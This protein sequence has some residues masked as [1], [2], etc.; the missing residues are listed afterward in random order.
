MLSYK[1]IIK[2]VRGDA[3]T[4][5]VKRRPAKFTAMQTRRFRRVQECVVARLDAR[6]CYG[7]PFISQSTA[8]TRTDIGTGRDDDVPF[9]NVHS[10]RAVTQEGARYAERE[11]AADDIVLAG[12]TVMSK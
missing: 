12:N 4:F 5:G 6:W 2:A 11:S 9:L 10:P 3:K 7:S 8:A 1:D